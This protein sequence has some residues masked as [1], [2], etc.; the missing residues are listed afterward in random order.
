MSYEET[1]V[2]KRRRGI[3]T[4]KE[5]VKILQPTMLTNDMTKL[6]RYPPPEM[7]ILAVAV[8]HIKE[9]STKQIIRYQLAFF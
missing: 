3:L 6:A 9:P 5:T 4:S 8:V 2:M 7:V 1:S